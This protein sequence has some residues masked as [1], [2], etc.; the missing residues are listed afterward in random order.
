MRVL[1]SRRFPGPAWDALEDV[2][3]EWPVAGP[4][5]GVEILAVVAAPVDDELLDLLPDLRLVAN[6]G[7]GYDGIDVEACARRGVAVTNTPAALGIATADL[8]MALVLA[9]RRRLIEGDRFVREGK[10]ASGWVVGELLGSEI[11]GATLGIVGLGRIGRAVAE[12][13]RAFG[14][15][16][17]HT[18]RDDDGSPGYRT[19][20]D[21]LRES[22]VV[23]LH[24]P[25]TEQT[26]RLLD[27]RRLALLRDGACVV[28]TARGAIVDEDAL[29]AELASGR[30]SAGL[31]VFADEPHVPQALL[32]LPNVVLSPHVGS[33]TR[34]TREAATAELVANIKAALERRPLPNPVPGSATVS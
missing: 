4:R 9:T 5:P 11:G 10:W 18:R 8:T 30:L 17:L 2:T 27:A 21:L 16:V 12:R 33:A 23:T 31:D 7:V 14:M 22:D 26:H 32:G 28:N 6:Y 24:V 34:A 19:L 25:L 1:A 15:N 20:D 13:A 29:V 3:V